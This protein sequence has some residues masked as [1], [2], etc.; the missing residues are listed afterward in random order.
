MSNTWTPR[1][2][3]TV[4]LTVSKAWGANKGKLLLVQAVKV[5]SVSKAGFVRVDAALRNKF[6]RN[7]D[8]RF[9][10][11]QSKSWGFAASDFHTFIEPVT[12]SEAATLPTTNV[13]GRAYAQASAQA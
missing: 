11:W 1:I 12:P 10:E 5:T 4:K 9:K 7:D 8:R 3:E 2:G 6:K 13:A